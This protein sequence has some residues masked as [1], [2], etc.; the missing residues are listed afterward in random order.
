MSGDNCHLSAQRLFDER[1]CAGHFRRQRD[2]THGAGLRQHDKLT[3]VGF[4]NIC[5][6]LGAGKDRADEGAFN[7]HA[8]E[9][10]PLAGRRCKGRHSAHCV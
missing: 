4:A 7:M 1:A 6:L 3:Q 2:H 9:T 8:E 5:Y 10:R